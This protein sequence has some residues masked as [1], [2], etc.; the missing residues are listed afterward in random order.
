MVQILNFLLEHNYLVTFAT[1]SAP[2]PFMEDL[3]TMGIN[4]VSIAV[5]DPEFDRFIEKLDP[6]LVIFDRFMMEEQF[7]WRVAKFCPNALR[8]LDTEDLHF[9]RKK[10][11]SGFTGKAYTRD[12]DLE[13]R[14]IASI[15]RCDLSLIISEVEMDLLITQYKV[16]PGL[17]LYFPF[18]YRKVTEAEK[19]MPSFEA[20]ND[21]IYIGNLR[22]APNLDAV[23]HLKE[24]IWPLIHKQLPGAQMHIYGAYSPEKIDRLHDPKTNFLIKGRAANAAEVVKNARVSLVPLRFGAGLKGKLTESMICGTP[25][26]T[27]PTGAEGINA[28]M[29]WNGAITEDPEDFT[30]AAVKLYTSKEFWEAAV[31]KGFQI[32]NTRFS[33]DIYH[34]LFLDHINELMENLNAYRAENFT[35]RMLTHHRVKSTYYLSKYIETKNALEK[36]KA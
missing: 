2:T 20:R 16:P 28:D 7:G 13:L 25:S 33:R 10:R 14:E 18:L 11:E 35:G 26:V 19:E 23:I 24:T 36:L 32:I 4:T 12:S 29:P 1:P 17:L 9:L 22:H 3:P 21:F 31:E 15:Y 8:I 27:T 30:S 5:N 34:A 6:D